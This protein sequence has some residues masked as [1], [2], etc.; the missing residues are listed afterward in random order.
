MAFRATTQACEVCRRRKVKVSDADLGFPK[1]TVEL[2]LL[3]LFVLCAPFT[4]QSISK[5]DGL[6]TCTN[7]QLAEESCHYPPPKKRGPKTAQ[8]QEVAP[9][10]P[11]NSPSTAT[12]IS[13]DVPGGTEVGEATAATIT[14]S[15]LAPSS[16]ASYTT[17]TNALLASPEIQIESAIRVHLDF[18]V[19]LHAVT[20]SETPLSIANH[21][22][23]LYTQYVF[24]SVPMCQEANL[25]AT[26]Q[27]FFVLPSTIDDSAQNRAWAFHCLE[28]GR[29]ETEHVKAL[30]NLTLLTALCAAVTYVVPE[31]LLPHKSLAAPLFLRTSRSMLSVYE[32]YDLEHPDSSSLTIRM[33]LSSAIQIATGSR[34][35]AFHILNEA[36]I[37]AMRM[38]LYDESALEGKD[39]VEETILRNAFWQLYVC[40]KTALVVKDRPV[41][42]HEPLFEGE[43]SLQIRSQ[44]PVSLFDYGQ[45]TD[46]NNAGFEDCLLNGFHVIRRL[47]TMAARL[48]QSVESTRERSWDTYPHPRD[49]SHRAAQLSE[50][51]FEMITLA[52]DPPPGANSAKDSPPSSGPAMP[53]HLSDIL[54]R[55][56]TSYLVSLHTI[57]VLV[58]SSL[59]ESNMT[60]IIGLSADPLTLAMRQVEQAQDFLNVLESVPFLHLQV[61]GEQCVSCSHPRQ[62][63]FA[64][65]SSCRRSFTRAYT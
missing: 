11:L 32:D 54:Y 46:N 19:A 1:E 27:R 60:E 42:I 51:Y 14:Y 56:R 59:I 41:T 12:D 7:C 38:H 33:F 21:C 17:R 13:T 28:A 61:E 31:S 24:G 3:F 53:K 5:C 43:L 62:R 58:L 2:G 57:K 23:L 50:A 6:P 47:W 4:D 36:C 40:D 48:I 26:A 30:R 39:P 29:S 15:C 8:C 52:N 34:G 37:I 63:E 25:R 49:S 55:Q 35:V 10:G 20:L 45:N 64:I 65:C 22:I 16:P 9:R 18:L 44:H